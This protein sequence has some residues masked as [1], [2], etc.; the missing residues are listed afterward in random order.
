MDRH[1]CPACQERGKPWEGED[2]R[3]AFSDSGDFVSDNWNCATINRLR[4]LAGEDRNMA[5]RGEG[6]AGWWARDDIDAGTSLSVVHTV[7]GFVV[8]TYYKSRGAVPQAWL[9]CD[10]SEP[11]KLR[12]EHIE[13]L[14]N[15]PVAEESND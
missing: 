3:C 1:Q 5:F 2:P 15:S 14:L 10:D 12:Y 6:V 11:T 8:L 13:E 4:D 9:H 7:H